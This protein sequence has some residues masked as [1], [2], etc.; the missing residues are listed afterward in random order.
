MDEPHGQ[1][2]RSADLRPL[3]GAL[4]S[5]NDGDFSVRSATDGEGVLGEIAGV[6]NQIAAR[7]EHLAG[8]LK[9][10]RHE[11]AKEGQLDERISASPGQGAW[12]TNV[13]D[14]NQL[15]EALVVPVTRTTRVLEAVADGDLT[16]HVEL[17]DG[18]RQ[19]RGDLRTS[20][21]RAEP[22]GG[23][24]LD[25]HR[26]GDEGRPRGRHRGT[27]RRTGQGAGISRATGAT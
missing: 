8:E 16:Q 5:L 12:A 9:R 24:A 20:G 21:A 22:S 15:L 25:V 18:N 11:V 17:H 27:A 1:S 13:D 23:P 14:A 2:V 19:L 26:R 4:R 7:N 6:F 3:L 10:V